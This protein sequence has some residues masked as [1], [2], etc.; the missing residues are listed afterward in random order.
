MRSM[1]T[2]I[3][4]MGAVTLSTVAASSVVACGTN[5]KAPALKGDYA[6]LLG[7]YDADKTTSK[8]Q[9]K[10]NKNETIANKE[11]YEVIAVDTIIMNTNFKDSLLTPST[12]LGKFIAKSADA[13]KFLVELGFKSGS[14]KEDYENTEVTSITHLKAKVTSSEAGTIKANTRNTDFVVVAGTCQISIIMDKD[15]TDVKSIKNYTIN[16]LQKDDLGVPSEVTTLVVVGNLGLTSAKGY[17]KDGN[18][19]TSLPWVTKKE[20]EERLYN[21]LIE[22]IGGAKLEWYADKTDETVMT[23]YPNTDT[24]KTYLMVKSGDVNLLKKRLECPDLPA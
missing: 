21:S 10:L 22:L 18:V 7:W 4:L 16:T 20:K 8:I 23:K 5:A 12:N 13:A 11:K 14:E 9:Q 24:T 2:L 3:R 6:A 17:K 1:K 19:L 15:G